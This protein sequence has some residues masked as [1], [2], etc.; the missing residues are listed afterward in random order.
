MFWGNHCQFYAACMHGIRWAC[1]YILLCCCSSAMALS[2]NL[3]IEPA[4]AYSESVIS[5]SIF[6]PPFSSTLESDW[7]DGYAFT[8][9]V[10][11]EWLNTTYL[12]AYVLAELEGLGRDISGAEI[13]V[14]MEPVLKNI[15]PLS[16]SF[17]F[18]EWVQRPEHSNA[19]DGL[20]LLML[21]IGACCL[22]SWSRRKR[23]R[24]VY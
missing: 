6:I 5:E 9:D 4:P 22:L 1:A 24:S 3:N 17:H 19:P 13:G 7:G 18:P 14:K 20:T 15:N 2:I 21:G 16:G 10:G 23:L 11:G 8:S 12:E